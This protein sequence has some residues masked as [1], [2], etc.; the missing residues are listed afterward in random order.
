MMRLMSFAAAGQRALR[1]GLCETA[2][3][4]RAVIVGGA[5]L[6]AAP[7]VAPPL[8]AQQTA[9]VI[10]GRVTG[11]DSQPIANAQITAVSY[12]GGITKTART[13]K[14]GRFSI[15]YANGEGDYW[16][17]FTAL[18]F[19]PRRFEV[20]RVADEEVLL[21]DIKLSN[22]QTLATVNVSAS[23]PAQKVERSSGNQ[24]DVSGADRG[25]SGALVS[26]EQAGNL[27]AMASTIPGV[28]LIPGLDGNPDRFSMFG[29]D[30]SQN[31]STLNGQQ[32]GLNNIPRDAAVSSTVRAGYDVANGGFSGAQVSVNTNSGN[33]YISR[34]ASAVFNSPQV[35]W[36]DRVGKASEY[37]NISLGGRVSGPIV[38]DKDFYN[39]AYQF[40]R[41]SQNLATLLSSTPVVFQSA[42]IAADSAARLRSILSRLGVPTAT[43]GIGSN[44]PRTVASL[45]GTFDW[46][47]KSANSGHAYNIAFNG[48]WNSA[49]P[50]ST[51]LASQT[52]AS[53]AESRNMSGGVQLRHTNYF[54]SGVLTESMV[55]VTASRYESEPYLT[56][57]G[58]T[59]LVTSALDDGSATAR[60]LTFGGGANAGSN[61][62]TALSARNMLSWFTSNNKH[63]IKLITELRADRTSSEQAFNLLGRYTYQSLADVDAGRPSSFS[64]S[65][66]A[67]NQHGSALVGA[68]A[69]GDAW[70]PTVN[71]QV[72]YGLRVDANRF[73]TRPNENPALREALGVV[74]TNVPN[75]AYVSPRV[76][77]SWLYG[78][79]PQIAFADGFFPGPRATIRGGIGVFQ[80]MRGPDLATSAIAN[81]GLPGSAQQLICTGDATPIVDWDILRANAFGAPTQCANGTSGTVFANSRP[82]VTLFS[83]GYKQEKSLRS[84]LS[85]TGVVLENRFMLTLNG[86]Y[87]YNFNQPD[88]IDLNFRPVPQFALADEGA[89]PVYVLSSSIDP[90]SGLIASRDARV[91]SLFNGVSSLQSTLHSQTRQFSLQLAPFSFSAQ[92]FRWNAQY[93]YLNVAEQYRGFSST[94]SDP[95]AL[96][97]GSAAGPRHDIGYSLGYTLANAVT[98]TWGGRLTSGSRFTPLIAGD[99]N[100]DGRSNDRAFVFDPAKAGDAALAAS[101]RSLLESGSGQ[102]R[103]CLRSQLGQFAARNSCVGPW[104]AGNTTLRIAL[105]PSRIRLPQ[106]TTL[107]FTISNPIGA[108]DLLLHGESKLHGWGQTPFLDQSLLFVRGFDAASSRYKYEVNQRFGSTRAAQTLSRTPVV[109]TMQMSFDMAPTRDWQNLRQ[110]LDRGRSRGGAKLTEAQVRQLSTMIPNP[111]AQLLSQGEQLH[112]SRMQADSLATMSRR[113]TRLLDSLWTPAAKYMAA[114]P[115]QYDHDEA[116]ERLIKMRTIVVGYLLTAAPSAKSMLTKG[117]LR[118][119]PS[120]I[121]NMLETRY[122]ELLRMG[123]SG[124]EF[125]YFFY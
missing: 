91:S 44:S 96:A 8:A 82:S 92:K 108:A 52:P 103:S 34:S 6:G 18:G 113:F 110:Q 74:N 46:A 25:V 50:Q 123:Q 107:S 67:V 36:N 63:R 124:S 20:K 5:M 71:L 89:R 95:L 106:R 17:S 43:G 33:N 61:A 99:V 85:W 48:S 57:P 9:D 1:V 2:L 53:L 65:L 111:M 31:N 98:F 54:G 105:N 23:G 55:S 70:R 38:M 26:P 116:Q 19:Q 45:L 120:Y 32:S 40:D 35:Q 42:G 12:F 117:Q 21:A 15:T 102:A 51:S 13:D 104:T 7:L 30:G 115:K 29:L 79:A 80:N 101:M 109:L 39:V 75:R 3:M 100:G 78:K 94:V 87:S 84:N 24:Q 49:G 68:L 37:T 41:R 86:L 11:P 16:V 122:L 81:T 97:A 69:L 83:P 76:G 77:F 121:A 14:N 60:S 72:Q 125:S 10:R 73:L 93:S 90:R 119:L 118:V 66:N 62:S 114:Q 27:A 56:L 58:G 28:Q 88:A 64:R 112:L 59:V 47:P 4:L 22:A